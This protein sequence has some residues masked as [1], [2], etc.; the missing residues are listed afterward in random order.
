MN[1][2]PHLV[3][4]KSAQSPLSAKGK[5]QAISLGKHLH[6]QGISFDAAY[7][8]DLLRSTM[9]AEIA[10]KEI[11]IP[12]DTIRLIPE[13]GELAQGDWEGRSREETYTPETLQYINT[14][15]A[16]FTSPNGESQ[17][18]VER[19]I[20]GWFID[21]ILHNPKFLDKENT[22]AIFSHGLAI[23]CF[24]HFVMNFNDRL[25]YRI[26][27]DNT[28]I[29]KLRFTHEGWFVDNINDNSHLQ[30]EK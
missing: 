17:M 16:S 6:G 30:Y 12:I 20:S 23:S 13:L 2:K 5:Q 11:G 29:C 21:E 18:T 4:G 10:L 26:R 7:S 1:L 19:R 22:I 24:L 27:L 14:K 8:S 3:G 9:T 15:G 25:I 28:A